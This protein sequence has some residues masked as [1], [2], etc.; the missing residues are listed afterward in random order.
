MGIQLKHID[1]LGDKTGRF[2]YRVFEQGS[3]VAAQ[4]NDWMIHD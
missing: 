2:R 1:M 3:E 4:M